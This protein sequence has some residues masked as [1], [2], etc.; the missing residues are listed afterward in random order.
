MLTRKLRGFEPF[1]WLEDFFNDF[2][3]RYEGRREPT[4]WVP[5]VDVRETDNAYILDIELPGMKKDQI[6]VSVDQGRLSVSGER[7]FEGEQMEGGFNHIERRFGK[8]SRSFTLPEDV[9]PDQIDASFNDGVLTLS[10][11]KR[12]EIPGEKTRKIAV[13]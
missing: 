11:V 9:D 2:V 13:S 8:F 10:L 3:P 7:K 6:D 1:D 5:R 12:G 4:D